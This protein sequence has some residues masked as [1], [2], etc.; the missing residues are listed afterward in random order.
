MYDPCRY[1]RSVRAFNMARVQL[2]IPDEDHARFAHQARTEQMSLSAWLRAAA[3]ERLDRRSPIER[4]ESRSDV[5]SFFSACDARE[6]SGIEP[7][8]EQHLAV[9]TESRRRGAAT[10]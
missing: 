2:L 5:E 4:F 10:E 8:W 7:D 6:G 9:I 3:N 1:T